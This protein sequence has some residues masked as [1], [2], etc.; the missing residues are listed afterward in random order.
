MRHAA[1]HP[2]NSGVRRTLG[3]LFAAV[4]MVAAGAV[5]A[6]APAV[7]AA[8]EASL[9]APDR[10]GEAM[11]EAVNAN[12]A[13]TV[14][15]LLERGVD[16]DYK[17]GEAL[18]NA[19][20]RGNIDIARILLEKGANANICEGMALSLAA[21]RG[22]EAI[23]DMLL[24]NPWSKADPKGS[25][26]W[27]MG[28]AA[29][30]GFT[31]IVRKLVEAGADV[32]GRDGF[33]LANAILGAQAETFNL[34]L[35]DLKADPNAGN[36]LALQMAIEG[37]HMEFVA[38]LLTLG[39]ISAM[40]AVENAI[41]TIEKGRK[42]GGDEAQKFMRPVYDDII[43]MVRKHQDDTTKPKPQTAAMTLKPL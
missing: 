17:A 11:L 16:P 13:A 32:N 24:D 15:K 28:N 38:K 20:L 19:V 9:V 25:D 23:V 34:L 18:M 40:P 41:S 26:Y 30:N 14:S 6:A 43:A 10:D 29:R 3:G 31:G 7:Q 37:G 42:S 27:A 2:Q 39:A 35:D 33:A 22:H 36:G 12:D 5:L 1:I 8:E 21:L 4:A